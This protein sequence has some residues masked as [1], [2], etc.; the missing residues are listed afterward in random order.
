MVAKRYVYI[1][2]PGPGRYV[3]ELNNIHR[4]CIREIE[5]FRKGVGRWYIRVATGSG[6]VKIIGRKPRKKRGK[7]RK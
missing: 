7:K 6:T 1:R 3:V 5:A 4:R 2:V